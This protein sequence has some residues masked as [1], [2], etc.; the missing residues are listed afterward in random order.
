[1][2]P[3][4]ASPQAIA[5]TPASASNRA[6]PTPPSAPAVAP[7]VSDTAE[8]SSGI[9]PIDQP[10]EGSG[11]YRLLQA[12]H[13][14]GVAE[15]RQ[16]IHFADR[17]ASE[18]SQAQAS[19]AADSLP[20]LTDAVNDTFSGLFETDTLTEEQAAAVGELQQAFNEALGGL[21]G[22]GSS[23]TSLSVEDIE[24]ALR[25]A[26]DTLLQGLTDLNSPLVVE[27]TVDPDAPADDSDTG[28]A[29]GV[30]A[31][32]DTDTPAEPT[33]DL[34]DFIQSLSELLNSQIDA[35]IGDADSLSILP[36]LSGPIGQG[37]AYE[38][39]LAT[40]LA[41]LSPSGETDGV[42]PPP[43]PPTDPDTTV[44]LLA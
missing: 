44:D 33:L 4:I 26:A 38:K 8:L 18:Q 21:A 23:Q 24:A 10:N 31:P 43:D 39:H 20:G 15:L 17:I 42:Q 2:I 36:E 14:K 41:L 37:A 25:A 5:H 27:E 6:T 3:S 13:F 1:M 32:A 40:Y 12:G 34:T 9:V 19:Q 29:P 35:L 28:A 22:D 11:A 30:E 7:P 16:R